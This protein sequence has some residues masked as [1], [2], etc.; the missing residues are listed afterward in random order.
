M[1]AKTPRLVGT[2]RSGVLGR[3]QRAYMRA[4]RADTWARVEGRVRWHGGQGAWPLTLKCEASTKARRAVAPYLPRA[5]ILLSDNQ[6]PP[7]A[8]ELRFCFS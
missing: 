1:R 8:L 2:Q 5:G 3:A 7:S 6:R 4:E